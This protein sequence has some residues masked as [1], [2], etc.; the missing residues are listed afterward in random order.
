[1]PTPSSCPIPED[2]PQRL[3]AVRAMEVLDTDSEPEFDALARL[4]AQAFGAPMAVVALMDSDRLWFKARLGLDMP[5]LD[6]HTAFCA[7]TV[8]TPG[9][10]LIVPDLAAEPR[11]ADHPMVADGPRLRFYAGAPIVDPRG[12]VLGTVAVL[13]AEPRVCTAVQEQ[14]LK[15]LAFLAMMALQARRRAMDLER[16]A[17][18]DPLTGVANRAHF[19]K[20]LE[21]ESGY[22]MRTGEPFS[23]VLMDLDGFRHTNDTH[24]Y[25]AGDEVLQEV[26]RR[27]NVLLRK[28]DTLARLGGDEFGIVVRHG[29]DTA[30]TVLVDRIARAIEAPFELASGVH[31][32]LG[33][34]V[35]Q[36]TYTDTIASM[37]ELMN[38]A[39]K[40]LEQAKGQWEAASSQASSA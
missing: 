31:V 39:N 6:R 10:A 3:R 20:A 25:S 33:I 24:G 32:N 13:D 5:Q 15:D 36:A 37:A 11:F 40:A 38:L 16:L 26:A 4:A 12:H 29:D 1:M 18:T 34:S 7:H 8:M 2:E 21:A 27:L 19:D 22:A 35:G 28:G 17:L 30:A 14:A 23:V 9:Q